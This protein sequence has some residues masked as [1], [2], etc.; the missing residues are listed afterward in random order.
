MADVDVV[1]SKGKAG[2]DDRGRLLPGTSGNPGGR[3]RLPASVREALRAATPK[4]V[5]S[6]VSLLDSEEPKVR[7]AAA[8]ALLNRTIGPT[9]IGLS[10]TALEKLEDEL[11]FP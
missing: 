5:E 11:G 7:L 10:N 8:E 6:L 9:P 2:R 1:Q 4:A 3:P